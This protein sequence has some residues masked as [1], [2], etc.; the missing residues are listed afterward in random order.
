MGGEVRNEESH[1]TRTS[2]TQVFFETHR[3]Q[4]QCHYPAKDVPSYVPCRGSQYT[5]PPVNILPAT[6]PGDGLSRLGMDRVCWLPAVLYLITSFA[7]E[8]QLAPRG[9]SKQERDMQGPPE[10]LVRTQEL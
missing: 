2:L 7:A 8:V 10:S 1:P 5:G 6:C 9:Q 3:S 4:N